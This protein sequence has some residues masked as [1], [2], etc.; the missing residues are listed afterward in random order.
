VASFVPQCPD[1]AP[2][3]QGVSLVDHLLYVHV[4]SETLQDRSDFLDH[5][6]QSDDKGGFHCE[7]YD[8]FMLLAESLRVC[9]REAWAPFQP[10][11]T[12][13][14]TARRP[15]LILASPLN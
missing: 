7:L 9:L 3:P 14:V 1:C 15:P 10:P 8:G 2:A 11:L 5:H 6:K 13:K 12:T 4:N